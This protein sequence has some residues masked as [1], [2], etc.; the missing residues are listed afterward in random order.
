MVKENGWVAEK[1]KVRGLHLYYIE[2]LI[3]KMLIFPENKLT[4]DVL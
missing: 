3:D 4:L 2:C 1:R